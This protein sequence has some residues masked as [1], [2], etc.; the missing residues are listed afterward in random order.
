M[1]RL[2]TLVRQ[3]S[4]CIIRGSPMGRKI[5]ISDHVNE[6]KLKAMVNSHCEICGHGGYEVMWNFVQET[7][8]WIK[9][10]QKEIEFLQARIHFT[11][12]QT[13]D[14][15]ARRLSTAW[16][17]QNPKEVV[18]IDFVY[19]RNSSDNILKH[20][21]LT[22]NDQIFYTWL[23]T[24]ETADSN[25]FTTALSKWISFFGIMLW[26]VSDQVPN[27]TASLMNNFTEETRICHH[28]TTAYS[29][30]ANSTIERLCKEV[31]GSAKALL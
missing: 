12:L 10:R 7:F 6:L 5:W 2:G 19:M 30:W 20:A 29:P 14:G 1:N 26:R 16:D 15:L 24:C 18:H 3:M 11:V 17:G 28:I 9:M 4:R 31:A 22:K 25:A 27:F 8:L 21:L 23:H 13:R